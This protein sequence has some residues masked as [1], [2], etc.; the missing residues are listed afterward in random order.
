[1]LKLQ[2]AL[3]LLTVFCGSGRGSRLTLER[4]VSALLFWTFQAPPPLFSSS[5]ASCLEHCL[6]S[7]TLEVYF[8]TNTHTITCLGEEECVLWDGAGLGETGLSSQL[9]YLR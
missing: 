3:L 2:L 7:P 1:M 8:E 5:L 4:H 9:W 6:L